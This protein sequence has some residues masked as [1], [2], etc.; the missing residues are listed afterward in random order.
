MT[1]FSAAGAVYCMAKEMKRMNWTETINGILRDI[2]ENLADRIDHGAIA[3]RAG[4]S[5]Y[6]LQRI[7]TAMTG[8]SMAEYVRER[9]LSLAGQELQRGAKVIDAALRYGYE[10]PESFQKAFKRFHGIT[11]AAA[12]KPDAPL[13]W[14][15]PLQI[16][17]QL[18]GGG[19]MDYRVERMDRLHVMIREYTVEYDTCM[20]DIP[21]IWD[22]YAAEGLHETVPGMIGVCFDSEPGSEFVYGIGDFC[23]EGAAAPQGYVVREIPA[24]LWA[25]FR[26][27]GPMPDALQGLNRQIYTQ[28]M[29][30]NEQYLPAEGMNIEI[31]TEGDTG[32]ADYESFIWIPVKER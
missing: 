2:E 19:M 6:Y 1:G 25:K 24:H 12:K 31:Y 29:P 9:R 13:R 23:E 10:S 26:A 7:F 18:V 14:R 28:W 27:V 22:E 15:N 8:M 30:G 17:I 11:P 21:R 20:T 5:Q 16:R 32:A 4:L 3:R